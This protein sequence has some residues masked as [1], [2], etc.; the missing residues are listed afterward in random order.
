MNA[1]IAQRFSNLICAVEAHIC[2]SQTPI[3]YSTAACVFIT[4]AIDFYTYVS[5]CG[6]YAFQDKLN[7][8][9]EIVNI[10]ICGNEDSTH[11]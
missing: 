4:V 5:M 6:G 2:K 11:T 3:G 1:S 7:S 8:M 9:V 10:T